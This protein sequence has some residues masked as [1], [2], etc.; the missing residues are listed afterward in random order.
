[1]NR[2]E[3]R[4]TPNSGNSVVCRQHALGLQQ[5]L[6]SVEGGRIVPCI[7][8]T[9]LR[10]PDRSPAALNQRVLRGTPPSLSSAVIP[11]ITLFIVEHGDTL[12]RKGALEKGILSPTLPLRTRREVK[13]EGLPDPALR[14]R[15]SPG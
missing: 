6:R 13:W 11:F 5:R 12:T 14:P 4:Q 15:G 2:R 3:V 1:V 8:R 9:T 10:P 7:R